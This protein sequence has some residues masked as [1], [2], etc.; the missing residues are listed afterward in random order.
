MIEKLKSR[1]KT[2][3]Q[4]H[5]VPVNI[6]YFMYMQYVF[7][8]CLNLFINEGSLHICLI[9]LV[10]SQNKLYSFFLFYN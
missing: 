5:L 2:E 4:Y 1:D 3:C 8:M 7:I 9:K 6:K 10:N